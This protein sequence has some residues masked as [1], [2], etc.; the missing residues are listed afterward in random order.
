MSLIQCT[1][2]CVYQLDGPLHPG[3]GGSPR[4]QPG[5]LGCVNFVQMNGPPGPGSRTGADGKGS[6]GAGEPLQQRGSAS[7]MLAT[8]ISSRPPERPASPGSAW[9][10]DT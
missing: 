6:G 3:P 7:R 10:S 1:D 4:C 8:R 9:G 2:P 5:C